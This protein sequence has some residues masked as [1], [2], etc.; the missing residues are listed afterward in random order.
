MEDYVGQNQ[1]QLK[2]NLKTNYNKPEKLIEIV[3]EESDEYEPGQVIRQSP[4]A[5][6]DLWFD[7]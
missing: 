6:S 4:A 1:P 7:F 3:E 2:Q 5:G